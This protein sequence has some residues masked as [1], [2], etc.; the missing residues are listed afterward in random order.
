M[1]CRKLGF[2]YGIHVATVSRKVNRYL[3]F[4]PLNADIT[5]QYSISYSGIL[6][7]DGK[8][9][10]VKGYD[11]KI[12]LIWGAD[13]LTHDIPHFRL[14]PSENYHSSLR[15][16]H[17]L[18]LL[19]YPLRCLVSDD[20]VSFK[21]AALKIYPKTVIQTCTNHFKEN[22]RR[23]LKTRSEE[24][25][26]PFIKQLELLFS[27]KRSVPEFNSLASKLY[28]KW[29]DDK[30][31]AS[32]MLDLAKRKAELTA[33]T[34]VPKTPYTTN[35][36]EAYNSHLQGRLKTIKSFSNFKQASLWLNGYILKRRTTKFT[37]CKGKFKKLN[38][39]APLELT[40]QDN[41]KQPNFF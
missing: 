4:L 33:Y 37:D 29:Q 2:E 7:L 21:L 36:I 30:L 11:K 39:R 18:R 31:V 8:Y 12:S 32:V 9:V 17:S 40:L 15:Y 26:Q 19:N 38:G 23:A 22:V 20:N 41:Q 35:L 16:F 28:R 3:K 10:R 27:K 6:I 5:R 24:T 1:S 34:K 25:Y 14:A 13:Y